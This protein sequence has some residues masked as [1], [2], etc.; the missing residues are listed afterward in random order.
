MDLFGSGYAGLYDL[1]LMRR[2]TGSVPQKNV[3]ATSVFD[4]W[5]LRNMPRRRDD[6]RTLFASQHAALLII[7]EV[8][9]QTH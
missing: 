7:S 2:L 8:A 9:K 5:C 4:A 1:A 3:G 6:T